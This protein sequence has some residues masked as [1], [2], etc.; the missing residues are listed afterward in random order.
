MFAE[1]LMHRALIQAQKAYDLGEVPVGAIIAKD[2]E[3]IAEAHNLVESL[4]DPTAH[5]EV[6]AI[7]EATKK[8]NNWRLQDC[9]LCVTLEP[10]TMCAG[11]I[12]NS[13]L[14]TL[15]FGAS[16]IKAGAVGSLYDIAEETRLGPTPRIIRSVLAEKSVLLLQQFFN[17]RR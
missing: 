2:Q 4:R 12:R 7:R 17:Q 3:I 6:L 8:L 11:A 5:A 15:I 1:Q 16:D 13:R 10:C 14:A 9:I